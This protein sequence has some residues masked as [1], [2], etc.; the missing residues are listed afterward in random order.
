MADLIM[1]V[2]ELSPEELQSLADRLQRKRRPAETPLIEKRMRPAAVPMSYGQEALWLLERSR[3]VGPAYNEPLG[4]RL[5]GPLQIMALERGLKEI[6]RR[7]ESLRTRFG[8]TGDGQHVQIIDSEGMIPLSFFDLSGANEAEWELQAQQLAKT[9]CTRPFDLTSGPLGRVTLVKFSDIDHLLVVTLHHIICDGWSLLLFIR[10]LGMLYAG[11]LSGD[12]PQL[13]QLEFQYADY[14]LW[15]RD[16]LQGERLSRELGYWKK[17]LGEMPTDLELPAD[18]PRPA[19]LSYRGARMPFVFS[20]TLSDALAEM[21]RNEGVTLYVVLLAAFQLVVARWTGRTDIVVGSPVAGRRERSMEPLLGFFVNT[22][23]MRTDVSGDITFRELLHRVRDTAF[24]AYEHQSL[25][26]ERLV[27]E[28]NPP[29]SLARHALFQ[30]MFAFQNHRVAKFEWPGLSLRMVN[31]DRDI[32]KFDLSLHIFEKPEGLAGDV[33]YST[34]LFDQ[35][36]IQ[37]LVRS[38]TVLLQSIAMDAERTISCLP[39]M[40]EEDR[41]QVLRRWNPVLITDHDRRTLLE[42]FE[43]QAEKTPNEIAVLDPL[44]QLTYAELNQ[45]ANQL[46][47]YLQER[48]VRAESRVAICLGRCVGMIIGLLAIWKAGGVYVPLDSDQ[49]VERQRSILRDIDPFIVITEERRLPALPPSTYQTIFFDG[50]SP[51]WQQESSSN[52]NVAT[53]PDQAAWVIYTSGSTG[54]PKG[55]VATY[56][57]ASNFWR[58]FQEGI[59]TDIKP[60]SG[61]LRVGVNAPFNFDGSIKQILHLLHGCSL[62][63]VPQEAR[64]NP[65]A[66]VAYCREHEIDLIDGTPAQVKRWIE[67]GLLAGGPQTVLISGSAILSPLWNVLAESRKT[68]FYNVYGP[69]ECTVDSTVHHITSTD[70]RPTIGRPLGNTQ[71]Y[72]LDMSLE[73]VPVGV[74]GELYI[75]GM[76]VTRGYNNEPVMTAQAFLPDPFSPIAGA[77]MYKTGDRAR[78]LENGEVE[79]LGRADDQIKIRDYRIEIHEIEVVLQSHENVRDVAVIANGDPDDLRLTAYVV[80]RTQPAPTSRDLRQDMATKLPSYMVPTSFVFLETLLLT[81]TGKV[82]RK[83]LPGPNAAERQQQYVAPVTETEIG[84]AEIWGEVLKVEQVG[85][86]DNFFELGGHSLLATQVMARVRE[87]MGVE[88]PLSALFEMGSTLCDLAR[89]VEDAQ[90]AKSDSKRPRLL[91]KEKRV[92]LSFAQERLWFLEQ[93]ESL[94]GAYNESLGLRLKGK[95]EIGVLERALGEMVRRHET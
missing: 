40:S 25:P 88:M 83:A 69:T 36:T 34:D 58:A 86:D 19:T 45:Q 67:A 63:I 51:A 21:A 13:P 23:V 59:A 10:E 12:F 64:S 79:F 44:R 20:R 65:E 35:T 93:L 6:V 17:Q 28:L 73:P 47:R 16:R 22:L 91:R 24:G 71:I 61:Q 3:S 55:I 2:V 41:N 84:L 37:R 18:K 94:H 7:H 43:F 1:N 33:E 90:R 81:H 77:R 32:A 50:D 14:A 82:D 26:F 78:F 27:A 62:Y 54:R 68:T 66:F 42:I 11:F 39:I 76:G 53:Q 52:L 8:T 74:P 72:I 89:L 70:G 57:G 48:G 30:I 60:A 15:Q 49:P 80:P 56:G 75:G 5:S 31:V 92:P 9:E 29:R 87:R 95:L 46:A 38:L 85:I 4:V